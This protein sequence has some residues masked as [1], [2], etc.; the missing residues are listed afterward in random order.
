EV[1]G[2]KT[3][4]NEFDVTT[5]EDAV[6]RGTD[7]NLRGKTTAAYSA[8]P[9]HRSRPGLPVLFQYLPVLVLLEFLER[10]AR[11]GTIIQRSYFFIDGVVET[12]VDFHIKFERTITLK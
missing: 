11:G 3:A 6:E 12:G 7:E 9:V 4:W 2:H 10:H 1:E 8:F 5:T